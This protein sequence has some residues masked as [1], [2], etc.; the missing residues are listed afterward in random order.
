MKAYRF[1]LNP[2]YSLCFSQYTNNGMFFAELDLRKRW[3]AWEKENL[4][5][6]TIKN[7]EKKSLLKE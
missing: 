5:V 7:G 4:W 1:H 3:E 6:L 2:S